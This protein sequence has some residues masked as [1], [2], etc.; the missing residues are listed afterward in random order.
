MNK[1][2]L[3]MLVAFAITLTIAVSF[4]FIAKSAKANSSA[5]TPPASPLLEPASGAQGAAA[6]Y[7]QLSILD[8]KSRK[9]FYRSKTAEQQKSLWLVHINAYGLDHNL[10]AEQEKLIAVL[11]AVVKDSDFSKEG[12]APLVKWLSDHK[13]EFIAQFGKIGTRELL[14]NLGGQPPFTTIQKVAFDGSCSCN[15]SIP[16]NDFCGWYDDPPTGHYYTCRCDTSCTYVSNGCGLLWQA[17]CTGIC[18]EVN[19]PCPPV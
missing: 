15:G 2:A 12:R 18:M 11:T 10:N 5:V 6:L 17:E 16:G 7:S 3:K 14:V 4:A 8:E 1:K 19:D 9:T 13:P